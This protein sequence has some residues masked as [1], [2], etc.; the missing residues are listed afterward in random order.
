[1]GIETSFEEAFKML[2]TNLFGILEMNR[3]FTPMV[4]ATRG[5]IVFTGSISSYTPQPSQSVYNAS[6]A[7]VELYA[8][9]L[10]IEMQPFGV[11]VVLV[12]TAG[13]NTGMSS[14][15]VVLGPSTLLAPCKLT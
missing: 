4:I 2:N 14:D 8:R 12:N 15:R 1:M 10:G 7:A 5:K 6:K 13:V 3:V 9:T 11:R